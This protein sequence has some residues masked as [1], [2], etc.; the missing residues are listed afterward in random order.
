MNQTTKTLF[1]TLTVAALLGAGCTHAQRPYTFAGAA[2]L[3][4]T[5]ELVVKALEAE[6]QVPE[7]VDPRNG[8]V[9]TAWKDTGFRFH[10]PAPEDLSMGI[11]LETTV[12]RRY[13][14][15]VSESAPGAPATVHVEVQAKRCRPDV[16]VEARQIVGPCHDLQT[17]FPALQM[18]LDDLGVRIQHTVAGSGA[19][20]S[21]ATLP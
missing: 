20:T 17:L 21:M 4:P 10:D 14:V 1:P 18:D 8:V 7:V 9:F 3:Q 19:P 2:P 15:A 11:E 6:G 5:T 13:H 16:M 12:F